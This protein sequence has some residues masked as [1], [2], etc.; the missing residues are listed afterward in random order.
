MII[1]HSF[2]KT[3]PTGDEYDLFYDDL[4]D[5]V[6]RNDLKELMRLLEA[7]ADVNS[8]YKDGMTCL[9]YTAREGNYQA[10]KLMIVNNASVNMK[11]KDN[12]TALFMA[13]WPARY[14]NIEIIRLLLENGA[15]ANAANHRGKTCLM[16]PVIN[17]EA[18]QLL[19]DYKA[20]INKEDSKGLTA[21][22]HAIAKT[23]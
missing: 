14:L 1:N 9:M 4:D 13:C 22:H 5:E 18:A 10:T 21:L 8:A 15:D 23:I 12:V 7:G 2:H 17:S 11:T 20:D 16:S 19:L 6:D 3:K